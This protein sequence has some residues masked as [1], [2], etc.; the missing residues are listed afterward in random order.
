MGRPR[1]T[2]DDTLLATARECV[3]ELGPGV[4][5]AV[6]ADR[7]GVSQATLFKRFGTKEDLLVAALAPGDHHLAWIETLADG[8]DDRPLEQQL[9]EVATEISDFFEDFMPCA[10]ALRAAGIDLEKVMRSHEVPP[11]IRAR[12]ALLGWFRRAAAAGRMH[13]QAN[14]EAATTALLGGLQH[15]MFMRH[16]ATNLAPDLFTPHS[17]G[18]LVDVLWRGIAPPEGAS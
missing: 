11:P 9:R 14:P 10:A 5:T 1:Q 6:I 15:Q 3:L 16:L 18:D 2:T 12:R 13:P 4:S 17:H 8:P 7:A